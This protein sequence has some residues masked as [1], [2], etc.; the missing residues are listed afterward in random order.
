[1]GNPK[2]K[3]GFDFTLHPKTLDLPLNWKKP[4]KIFVNSMSDLFHESMPFDFLK[5]CFDVM[6][7]ANWH[8]FQILTKRPH[9]IQAFAEVFGRFPDHIWIGTSVELAMFKSRIDLLR[10]TPVRIKFVSFEPLLGPLGKVDLT[11]I[12]WAIVGGE[13]GPNHRPIREEWVRDIK[14][15]C[16]EQGVAFFF[17]QWGGR[18]PKS[19][20]R[21]LDGREWSQ[22]PEN[23]VELAELPLAT[24]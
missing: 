3:N 13:S 18:T 19:G 16:S 7:E 22:Y 21:L 11:D 6:V 8:V 17:K 23:H 10:R 15:Q 5:R 24:Q 9:R 14:R 2:Y 12:S 4:R 20:G 1:M